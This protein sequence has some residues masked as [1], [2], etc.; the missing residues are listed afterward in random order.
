MVFNPRPLII[1]GIHF[2][3]AI[4]M[5]PSGLG[6]YSRRDAVFFQLFNLGIAAVPP[7]SIIPRL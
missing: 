2:L 6:P 3:V 7:S 1:V 4:S 5:R